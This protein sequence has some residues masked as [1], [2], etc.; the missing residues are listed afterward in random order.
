MS[1]KFKEL[2]D[3]M[4]DGHCAMRILIDGNPDNSLDRI[5]FIEKT[6]RVKIDRYKCG[7]EAEDGI[8]GKTPERDVW[9]SGPKGN[10]QECGLYETS[11]E[12]CDKM[13]E[14]LGYE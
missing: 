4:M 13:L 14:L 11:R 1:R 7:I 2:S 8:G 10:G 5:A 12:W 3:W 9:I 6:P